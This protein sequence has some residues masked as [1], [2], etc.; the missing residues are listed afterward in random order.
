[1]NPS[2]PLRADAQRNRDALLRAAREIFAEEQTDV[3]FEDVARR[4]GVGAGTLYRHFPNRDALIAAV[5]EGEVAALRDRAYHLM[6]TRPPDEALAAFLREMVDHMYGQRGLARTFFAAT[7]A[8]GDTL[9]D[10]G[11]ALEEAVTAILNR[12]IEQAVLRDD[13]PAG[14]LMLALHGI[15]F[16][17]VHSERRVEA[18]GIVQLMIDGLRRH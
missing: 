15:G 17:S 9:S 10:E 3:P 11:Q 2:K 1:M 16:A 7:E 5:Y 14:A 4:A 8:A 13:V 12:G 6:E 18:D